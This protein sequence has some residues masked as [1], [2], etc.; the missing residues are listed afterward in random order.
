MTVQCQN[1]PQ[2]SASIKWLY[3]VLFVLIILVLGSY[4]N[5]DRAVARV[6]EIDKQQAV[7]TADISYIKKAVDRI[8]AKMEDK[9]K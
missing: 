7:L 9:Q 8:D 2:I 4:V 3:G 6:A 5:T 1:H